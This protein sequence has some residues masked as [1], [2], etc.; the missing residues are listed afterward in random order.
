MCEDFKEGRG[1]NGAKLVIES[2]G[3][4]RYKADIVAAE[5]ALAL[6]PDQEVYGANAQYQGALPNA[7]N[8]VV[9]AEPIYTAP[10]QISAGLPDG[11]VGHL[12]GE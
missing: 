8:E 4:Y 12:I 11:T 7:Q 5:L 1:P 9:I 2:D 6:T 3:T 10:T